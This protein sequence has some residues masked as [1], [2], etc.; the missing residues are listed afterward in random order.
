[1]QRIAKRGR[2]PKGPV[3]TDTRNI[4][5]DL[6]YGIVPLRELRR[7]RNMPLLLHEAGVR[8]LSVGLGADFTT[9]N[10]MIGEILDEICGEA[11]G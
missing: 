8:L 4:A 1:M 7:R 5:E 11:N 3:S 10:D 2:G 6:H 9:E